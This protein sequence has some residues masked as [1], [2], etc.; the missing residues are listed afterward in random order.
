MRAWF[1][2]WT[3]NFAIAGSAFLVIALIVLVRGIGD[4]RQMFARLHHEGKHKD[5]TSAAGR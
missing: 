4:L 3:A 5:S 2:F 1:Y